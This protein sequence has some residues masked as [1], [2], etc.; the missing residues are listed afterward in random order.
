MCSTFLFLQLSYPLPPRS[1]AICADPSLYSDLSCRK[2]MLSR[3]MDLSN[4]S[5]S[6]T[7]I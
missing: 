7:D 6:P 5:F 2:G 3:S 4:I 1:R